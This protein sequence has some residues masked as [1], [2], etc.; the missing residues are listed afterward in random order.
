MLGTYTCHGCSLRYRRP[1]WIIAPQLDV[2]RCTPK[3]SRLSWASAI[4][5]NPMASDT[6]TISG[7]ATFGSTRLRRMRPGRVPI[8]CD[9]SMKVSSRTASVCARVRRAK[10]GIITNEMAMMTF[11]SPAPS[12]P[13]TASASTS[14]GKLASP[15]ITRMSVTSVP[16]P[17]KPASSPSGTAMSSATPTIWNPARSD[18]RAP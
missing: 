2:G 4:S 3:P 7:D 1:S 6:A 17:R 18:T 12:T 8:E 14:G 10:P 13:T 11:S 15:S 16:P 9:A 5:A